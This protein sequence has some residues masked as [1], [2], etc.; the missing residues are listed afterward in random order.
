MSERET[1][2]VIRAHERLDGLQ[3]VVSGMVP[4]VDRVV[5][6]VETNSQDVREI[7]G[8]L[9]EHV[10]ECRLLRDALRDSRKDEKRWFEWAAQG[11]I[12]AL[13]LVVWEFAKD[14]LLTK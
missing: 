10:A 9:R 13:L 8:Q 11:V 12:V 14:H 7:S 2:A 5:R 1:D 4:T 3:S 6:A